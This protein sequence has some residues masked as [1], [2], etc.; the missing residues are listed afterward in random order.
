MV[1]GSSESRKATAVLEELLGK[2]CSREMVSCLLV[3]S[4]EDGVR[5][6]ICRGC[7]L[8]ARRKLKSYLSDSH[9]IAVMR[10]A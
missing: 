5:R 1:K 7:E 4:R 3:A 8:E 2:C 9:P 10:C 6:R